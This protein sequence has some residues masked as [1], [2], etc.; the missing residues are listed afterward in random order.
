MRVGDTQG[1]AHAQVLALAPGVVA[2]ALSL[3]PAAGYVLSRIDGR[4]T[5]GT[6]RQIGALPP[7]E[8]DRLVESWLK[9]GVLIAS[10]KAIQASREGRAGAS[11]HAQHEKKPPAA[12]KKTAPPPAAPPAAAKPKALALPEVDASLDLDVELQREILAF[13]GG[14]GRRYH[15][16]LGVAADAD[17]RTV[18]KAYFALSKKLHPDRYFRRN[19][20]AFA[21]LIETCFKRLLEAYEL[22]SDPTTRKEVQHAE[23]AP[24][25]PVA[26]AAED[27]AGARA[28]GLEARRRL[29]ERVSA[30]SSR[31]RAE[32]ERRRKAKTFFEHGMSAFA[33]SRWV[34]AAGAVRLAIAFDPENSAYREEFPN[35]QRKAHEER[36]KQLVKQA[37]SALEMRDYAA[38]LDYFEEA[39]HYRP[40]DADLAFRS[41]KLAVQVSGDLKRAKEFAA[42]AV[43][44]A[45]DN[46]EYRKMLASV[47][48][49]AGLEANAKR[50][51]SAALRIDPSDK[52]AKAGLRSL[53]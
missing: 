39:L 28:R 19:T 7:H 2:T 33:A 50:E 8:V 44:V 24:P 42:Q 51:Y 31:A 1:N 38:A 47:Y 37:E 10:G 17:A 52:E 12:Q 46:A 3:D 5:W 43:E 23:A 29:R 49:A 26:V 14:L 9:D 25:P 22:L 34:E 36:A 15:E 30:M 48:A 41:A 20:G 45:P 40:G 53:S 4:T 16:L 6:L 11:T 27:A 13:A 35:V 32:G 18:K 21:P